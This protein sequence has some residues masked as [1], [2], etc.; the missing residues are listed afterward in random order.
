MRPVLRGMVQYTDLLSGAVDLA[1]LALINDALDVNDENAV[2]IQ[3]FLN[4]K[5]T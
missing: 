2:R 1:D 4:P 5:T 3:D